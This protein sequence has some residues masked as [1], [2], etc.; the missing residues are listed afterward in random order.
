M[1]I[2]AVFSGKGNLRFRLLTG[3]LSVVILSYLITILYTTKRSMRLARE[4]AGRLGHEIV[5]RYA[6]NIATD[7]ERIS[8]IL[9]GLSVFS[10]NSRQQKVPNIRFLLSR[11]M[12]NILETTDSIFGIWAVWESG[13]LDGRD[14]EFANTPG[15]DAGGRF[16]PYW[17]RSGGIHVEP[18]MDYQN[19]DEKGN[20]YHIPLKTRKPYVTPA[21]EYKIAGQLQ[22]VVSFAVP[23]L[24]DGKA[25]GVVGVDF[26]MSGLKDMTDAIR[27]S[28][29]GYAFLLTKETN[30]LAHPKKEFI[31]KSITELGYPE[32]VA[33]NLRSGKE[34]SLIRH[35]PALGKDS[36][37]VAVPIRSRIAGHLWTFGITLPIEEIVA[38]SIQTGNRIIAIFTL[39]FLILILIIMRLTTLV[40]MP[41]R[42]TASELNEGTNHISIAAREVAKA[43]DSIASAAS[44]QASSV[45]EI[46]G[47]LHKFGNEIRKIRDRLNSVND[48]MDKDIPASFQQ[49]EQIAEQM[50]Q[51]IQSGAEAAGEAEKVIRT[52]DD[53]A[54]QTNL[55]SLNA[56][57]EAARA[58]EAGAG[59]GVVADEIRRLANRATH[60]AHETGELVRRI[61]KEAS[62]VQDHSTTMKEAMSRNRNF[63]DIVTDA[64]RKLN[65]SAESQTAALQQIWDEM[66]R[67]SNFVQQNAAIAQQ[68]AASAQEL[69]HQ[70]DLIQNVVRR[71][72]VSVI[73][74]NGNNSPYAKPLP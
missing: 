54:F 64:I 34:T 18:C 42:R 72:S 27:P 61:Q 74:R 62:S 66:D 12:K 68:S 33:E 69:S 51:A 71:L 6:N 4:N 38:D 35:V 46:T 11:T 45:E 41:V 29:K 60:A 70:V 37:V 49:I 26:S 19:S 50:N 32:Y 2:K 52:V 23:I 31:G 47:I 8:S 16:V 14:A 48:I 57:I 21:V 22:T 25:V 43:S 36:L 58:G 44:H 9:E 63:A 3:I 73:G 39:S 1:D 65:Q 17:N 5:N 7:I 20:Y 24:I 55:L 15:H 13:E 10:V 59:F 30:V 53:I 56:A 40:I 28:E 67:I